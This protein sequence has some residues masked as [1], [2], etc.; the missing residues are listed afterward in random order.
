MKPSIEELLLDYVM[1]SEIMNIMQKLEYE[2][3]EQ[4]NEKM[5]K[6]L[7]FFTRVDQKYTNEKELVTY[8][9][10]ATSYGEIVNQ[11]S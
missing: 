9:P 8:L 7:A 2:L 5:N 4:L 6:N 10:I 11:L 3:Q 1:K